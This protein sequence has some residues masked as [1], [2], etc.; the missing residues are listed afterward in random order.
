MYM[1]ITCTI[2]LHN[3]YNFNAACTIILHN[4]EAMSIYRHVDCTRKHSPQRHQSQS[5]C[6]DFANTH[7]TCKTLIYCNMILHVTLICSRRGR[8][9]RMSKQ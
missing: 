6:N 9:K 3:M 8:W 7:I 1:Y 2:K 5:D 4:H